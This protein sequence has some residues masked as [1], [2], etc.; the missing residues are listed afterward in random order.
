MQ[1]LLADDPRI[2]LVAELRS[3]VD[4]GPRGISI[5]DVAPAVFGLNVRVVLVNVQDVRSGGPA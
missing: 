2:G 4:L 5:C 1:A 3:L